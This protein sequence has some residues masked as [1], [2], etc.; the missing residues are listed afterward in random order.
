[1]TSARVVSGGKRKRPL[2]VAHDFTGGMTA[3]MMPQGKVVL[4]APAR[5][6]TVT[7]TYTQPVANKDDVRLQHSNTHATG[8][9]PARAS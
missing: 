5:K 4:Q 2:R 3:P 7:T 1:M 9:A 6:T 8:P